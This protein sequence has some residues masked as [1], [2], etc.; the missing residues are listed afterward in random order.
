MRSSEHVKLNNDSSYIPSKWE[1]VEATIGG[2]AGATNLWLKCI[3]QGVDTKDNLK[4]IMNEYYYRGPD[5]QN[6]FPG[7][8]RSEVQRD[9]L[10]AGLQNTQG[11]YQVASLSDVSTYSRPNYEGYP[12]VNIG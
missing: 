11:E 4:K 6:Q 5:F 7:Q 12:P 3:S 8:T 2:T 1:V 10:T 9:A